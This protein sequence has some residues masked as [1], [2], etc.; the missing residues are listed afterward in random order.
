MAERLAPRERAIACLQALW[1]EDMPAC[2]AHLA[3]EARFIFAPSLPYSEQ[4]RS[5][6]AREAL[7]RVVDDSK[8]STK[9]HTIA[10]H[11]TK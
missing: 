4:G 3:P 5:W 8:A 7:Q 11:L 10:Q 9:T 1:R 2:F 6:D